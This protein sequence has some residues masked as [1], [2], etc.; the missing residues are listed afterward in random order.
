MK[1]GILT[2][3]LA[4][5]FA[6]CFAQGKL[7]FDGT[8][9]EFG[10]VKET[11]GPIAHDFKFKNT[12]DQPLII[13]NVQASCGCTTP[14]WTKT[15]IAPGQSGFIKAQ[16]NP[17]GRPGMFNKSLTVTS[18][19]IEPS[20]VLFIKGNVI[21]DATPAPTTTEAPTAPAPVIAPSAPA[22]PEKAATP[23]KKK[24]TTV[25]KKTSSKK[26]TTTK[27]STEKK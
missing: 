16:Y 18:N 6:F 1:K 15:P 22:T 20:S 2:S 5:G 19:A 10:D 13:S 12:G 25:T 11:G 14:D 4:L 17:L 23:V 3:V 8:S 26:T 27:K 9:H 7:E 24:S 21:P